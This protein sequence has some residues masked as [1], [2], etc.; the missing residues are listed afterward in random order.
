[1]MIDEAIAG[2]AAGVIGTLLGY[3]LDSVKTRM[4]AQAASGGGGMV[5]VTKQVLKE[6]GMAGFYRGVASPLAALT[7]LNTLNFSSYA[8][9][10]AL[11][12]VD[13]AVLARRFEFEWRVPAA[14]ATVGPLASLISTPF[15]LIKT[16]MVVN[17]RS[18]STAEARPS[19][20]RKALQ[21]VRDHGAR[22]LYVGHGVNTMREVVFLGT[23][24]T[25]YEHSK[26]VL[27]AALADVGIGAKGSIPVA[28]GVSG[29]IGWFVSFPL[30]CVKSNIQRVQFVKGE[31]IV[32]P[33]ALQVAS[34]L[35]KANGVAGLYSGVL[36][37][38][39]RAFL[40]SASRFTVFEAVLAALKKREDE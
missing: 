7:L 38:L 26:S 34:V 22:S 21:L 14:A 35:V 40:V 9:F 25:V 10:R 16:Q 17:A 31:A 12:G 20:L 8:H 30:D 1:M 23:Y 27:A 29:I 15:E 36:P 3:P 39:A 2:C 6:E 28:G 19:S 5:S 37:S 32:R 24:F 4:Q 13:D 18:T 33:G 11:Y